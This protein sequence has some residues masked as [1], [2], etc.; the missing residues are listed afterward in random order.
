M[1]LQ[2]LVFHVRC[3]SPEAL[4][5][6]IFNKKSLLYPMTQQG[7]PPTFYH[8][9]RWTVRRCYASSFYRIH[10]RKKHFLFIHRL[11]SNNALKV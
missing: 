3:I 4:K 1:D 8:F 9:V 10:R 11:F 5:T 2:H 7:V 6:F